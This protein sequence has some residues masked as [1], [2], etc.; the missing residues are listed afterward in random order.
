LEG[1]LTH[2]EASVIYIIAFIGLLFFQLGRW[3]EISTEKW[4]TYVEWFFSGM[5]LFEVALLIIKGLIAF[6]HS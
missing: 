2:G 3:V 1:T 5:L 4:A 6:G